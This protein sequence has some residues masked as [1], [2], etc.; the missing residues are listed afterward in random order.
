MFHV[1]W[2]GIVS[3]ISEQLDFWQKACITFLSLN[4]IINT[5][6]RF[7]ASMLSF[8][9]VSKYSVHS[10]QKIQLVLAMPPQNRNFYNVT[11]AITCT[12][13]LIMKCNKTRN[14]SAATFYYTTSAHYSWWFEVIDT[15]WPTH[16]ISSYNSC[17]MENKGSKI[18][19]FMNNEIL[20]ALWF[21][22]YIWLS[23]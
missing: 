6:A 21:I 15:R 13:R 8:I 20:R 12:L 5:S 18:M 7:S 14:S 1:E 11:A 2:S 16:T 10:I 22:A 19:R 23:C 9:N 3:H 17:L 4:L